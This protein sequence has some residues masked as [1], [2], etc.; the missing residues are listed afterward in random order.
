MHPISLAAGE[1]ADFFLLI[2]A[3]E[4]EPRHIGATV[5]LPLAHLQIVVPAGDFLVHRVVRFQFIA[6]LV[7]IAQLDRGADF[8]FARVGLFLAHQHLE[9]RGLARAVGADD[10]DDAARG[11]GGNSRF[12]R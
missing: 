1:D 9:Q 6:R 10:A 3:C 4:V 11:Q 12:R 8:E 2:G 5:H 7:D